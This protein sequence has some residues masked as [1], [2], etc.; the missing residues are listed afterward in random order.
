[1]EVRPLVSA[2]DSPNL[3]AQRQINMDTERVIAESQRVT[4]RALALIAARDAAGSDSLGSQEV[5]A[6]AAAISIDP[7]TAREV[8]DQIV[9]TVDFDSQ[10]LDFT[11]SAADAPRAR[12]L[13]QAAA[14]A[15]LDFRRTEGLS[16]TEQ[17]RSQLVAREATLIAELDALSAEIGSAG[18]DAARVQA[19]SYRDISKREEL[20]GIGAKLANL[21]AISVDPGEILTDAGI[22]SAKS[23]IPAS[24]G[25]VSGA[26]LGMMTGLGIA[27]VLDRRDDRVRTGSLELSEMGLSILGSVPVGQ[28]LFDH[29]SGSAIAEVNSD[30]GEAYRR[31]QGS[32]LFNLDESDKSMVLVAGTNNPHS[33]T[34]VAANLAVAAARAGRRTLLVGADLR[35]PSLHERFGLDN[36]AGLSDVLGGQAVLAEAIRMIPSIPNLQILTSGT[37]VADP[38]RVLQGEAFGRLVSSARD[39]FDLVVFEAPPVLQVADAVDLARLCQGAVLVVEPDRATRSGVA[40]SIEQLRRV[41]ADVLGTVIA[42]TKRN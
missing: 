6:A 12:D 35:R 22:P 42:E 8:S 20:A 17:A 11:A 19:L 9:V 10:I 41:G 39:A 36:N 33:S 5:E 29:A 21:G 7:D 34:T 26:L 1:V 40:D 3:D 13:A 18:D 24:A 2:G 27:F 30:E 37:Q 14:T 4:E 16:N 15:Y 23:G 25:P 31:V 28:G 32:L 38:A